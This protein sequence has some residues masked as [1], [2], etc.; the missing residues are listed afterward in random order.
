MML[1]PTVRKI[2]KKGKSPSLRVGN[3]CMMN[4]ETV[5]RTVVLCLAGALLLFLTLVAACGGVEDEEYE[6]TKR[7][8]KVTLPATTAQIMASETPATTTEKTPEATQP[9]SSKAESTDSPQPTETT[10]PVT[11]AAPIEPEVPNYHVISL[12]STDMYTGS[13]IE[14]NAQNPYSYKVASLH[15]PTELDRL[16]TSE[17]SELG[18]SSLYTSKSGLYLLRSRLIYLRT[19]AFTAFNLMMTNFVAKTGNRDLQVRYGYQLVN[20]VTDAASLS[21]ERVSGF[22]VEVNVYTE[23]GSFSIDHISKK[24]AYYDWFDENC[25]KYGFVMSGESGYFR[26][27]GTPHAEYMQKNRLTLSAYLLLLKQYSYEN[28]LVFADASGLLWNLYY[29]PASSGALTEVK[30]KKDSLY[31]VSGN[32]R[33]GFVIASRDKG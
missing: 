12:S 26:Y 2:H 20:S 28:P 5:K 22:V 16:S 30:L 25:A 11:S 13:L 17:L 19:E 9:E 3:E 21:D 7:N 4:K 18:W 14:I 33:D 6:T 29:V 10:A 23:E 24:A 15:T 1:V 32:N 8:S 31:L 27:V